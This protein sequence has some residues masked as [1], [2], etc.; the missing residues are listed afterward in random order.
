MTASIMGNSN[1]ELKQFLDN[2]ELMIPVETI[3]GK[4]NSFF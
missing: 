1:K 4:L 2:D 3:I